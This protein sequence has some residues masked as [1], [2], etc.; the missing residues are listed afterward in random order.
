LGVRVNAMVRRCAAQP[1]LL[2]KSYNA[3][4]NPAS[5][6]CDIRAKSRDAHVIYLFMDIQNCLQCL[7]L[8]FR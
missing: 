5:V 6:P 7:N 2:R 8:D 1:P 3:M 4:D